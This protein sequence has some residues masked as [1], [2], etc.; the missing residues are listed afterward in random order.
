MDCVTFTNEMFDF[1]GI[2]FV[3]LNLK[4]DLGLF[5]TQTFQNSIKSGV[6]EE[7]LAFQTKKV[8]SVN[9]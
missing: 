5:F 1:V 8:M 3:M 2:I 4:T 9:L 7:L 6:I